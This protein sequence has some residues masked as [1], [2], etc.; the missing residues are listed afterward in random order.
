MRK[1]RI[2]IVEDEADILEAN[3]IYLEGEGYEPFCAINLKEARNILWE[4]PPDLILLDVMLPDGSGFSFMPEIH[5]ATSAPVIFL[6][7]MGEAQ[8]IV[9][10]LALGADDYVT[11]PYSMAVLRARIE[12]R[13]RAAGA[14]RKVIEAP[15]FAIDLFS[16]KVTK[17]GRKIA[18]TSKET[19]MFAFFAE[20][21]G[22]E[23][24]PEEIYAAVWGADEAM[25]DSMRNTV[26]VHISNLRGKL[27]LDDGA[28]FEIAFTQGKNYAFLRTG[29]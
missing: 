22:R 29:A 20:H 21:I 17:G 5:R 8:D 16:G 25:P 27:R 14:G 12:A 26:R 3:R 4:T 6:T 24:S 13:L 2:L 11:K 10:G 7:A 15:P 9:D 23:L 19:Q 18:L 1:T 28:P